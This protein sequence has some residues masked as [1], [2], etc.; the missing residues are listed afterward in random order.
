MKSEY[1]LIPYTKINSKW[2]TDLNVRPDT[3]KPLEEVISRTLFDINY[4]NI[5]SD[6]PPRAMEKK[7]ERNQWGIIKLKRFCTAKDTLNKMTRQPTEWDK[8]FANEAT[9]KGL[10]SK[11]YK[12]LLQLQT[13]KTN[14][15]IKKMGR[16][17]K[18]TILQRRHID[19][20]KNT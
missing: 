20:Q 1:P 8:L 3:I 17:S 16:R 11:I 2:I 7:T 18:Q 13:K 14:N 12:Y 6:S 10:I 9:D 19:S 5:F 4:S 15:H